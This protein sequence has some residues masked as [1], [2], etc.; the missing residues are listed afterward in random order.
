MQTI[1]LCISQGDMEFICQ[2]LWADYQHGKKIL[3]S[4]P[5]LSQAKTA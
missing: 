2:N 1:R 3:A 4:H 5:E